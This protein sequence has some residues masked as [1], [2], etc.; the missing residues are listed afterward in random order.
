MSF[1]D[2]QF[3]WLEEII[4]PSIDLFYCT[5][6]DLDLIQR[7]AHERTIVANIYNKANTMINAKQAIDDRL[8]NLGIDI[9]Y[10]R[11]STNPKRVYEKCGMCPN[12]G[13]FIKARHL[14]YTTSSPDMII[15]HRGFN[16]NNQVVVEYKKVSN[17][18][19]KERDDDKA[20]LIYFTCQQ[21][22][23]DHENE[24]YQ[25]HT[26]FFIDLGIDRYFVT[27]FQDTH[28][29]EKRTRQGGVWL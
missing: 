27:T 17:R 18:N 16:D 29:D 26:G 1:R 2:I 28:S 4:A 12:E 14:Q 24:N 23:L 22:F 10:N 25:Y 21:P 3:N 13:C 20:K 15:H 6:K 9:E 11:N 8:E 5:P 7:K 19:N